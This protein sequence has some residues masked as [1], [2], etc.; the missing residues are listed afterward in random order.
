MSANQ[1]S[2]VETDDPNGPIIPKLLTVG[3]FHHELNSRLVDETKVRK[4]F[5]LALI[6]ETP[7]GRNILL[8]QCDPEFD[9]KRKERTTS[10]SWKERRRR[11]IQ[12]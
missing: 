10:A 6:A 4:L 7:V 3:V 2:L 8:Q 12:P 9:T 11:T 5:A 1:F